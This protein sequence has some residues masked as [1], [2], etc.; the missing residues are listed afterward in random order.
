MWYFQYFPGAD[1]PL[2]VP[3][4]APEEN[5]LPQSSVYYTPPPTNMSSHHATVKQI[6]EIVPIVHSTPKAKPV[7]VQ[8]HRL[9]LRASFT[10]TANVTILTSSTVD[11]FD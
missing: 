1:M 4:E 6:G 10:C 3:S 9:H 2:A 11:V 7:V 5:L 8:V